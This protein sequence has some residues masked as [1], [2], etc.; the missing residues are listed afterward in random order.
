MSN[1]GSPIRRRSSFKVAFVDNVNDFHQVETK[2]DHWDFAINEAGAEV[3]KK[4]LKS[5]ADREFSDLQQRVSKIM[6]INARL[7]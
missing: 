1:S 2:K 4:F 6:L 7:F 5:E 3:L